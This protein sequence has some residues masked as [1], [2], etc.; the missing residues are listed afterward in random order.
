M[1]NR[2][3]RFL[4]QNGQ[5]VEYDQARVHVLSVA[6]KYG[7]NVFEGLRGYWNQDRRELFIFRLDDHL[8]RLT[9]SM[10]ISRTAGDM[11][12]RSYRDGLLRLIKANEQQENLH[13][14]IQVFVDADDG[15]MAAVEP[16]TVSIAA[17]PMERYFDSEGRHVAVSSWTRIS[18]R[19]MPPRVKAAANYHN[20][21]LAL[22][23]A[24]VDGYDDAILLT[25]EGKASE[26]A[27]YSLFM[28]RSGE[29]VTPPVTG[30]I[31]ESITRDSIIR[32]AHDRLGLYVQQREIDRTE[33]YV[34]DEM[35]F[36]GSAAEV[37]P[38][39][40]VDR[41]AVGDG[42]TGPI[43]R[44][45]QEVYLAAARGDTA[46]EYGWLTPVY[47]GVPNPADVEPVRT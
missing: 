39:W 15:N 46:D 34:A 47:G 43:T 3:P 18:D 1:S 37:T 25:E 26:G 10:K 5:L 41:H 24:Q 38:I 16:V 6:F 17:M 42:T 36:C 23:Q 22:I 30:G 8:R 35:W 7:A 4:L 14:R 13:I 2:H 11:E 28:V 21:R 44:R 45:L 33:L 40:S 19:S 32:L 9:E 29:I 20:S 27:G 12:I 31:L